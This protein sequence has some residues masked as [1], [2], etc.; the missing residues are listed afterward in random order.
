MLILA[1]KFKGTLV[2]LS[3]LSPSQTQFGPVCLLP[4]SPIWKEEALIVHTS[5]VELCLSVYYIVGT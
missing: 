2:S 3:R 4:F 5:D 1:L